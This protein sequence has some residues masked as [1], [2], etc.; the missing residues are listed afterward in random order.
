MEKCKHAFV[1]DN[2][3]VG[4]SYANFAGDTT[5]LMPC[6]LDQQHSIERAIEEACENFKPAELAVVDLS[7]TPGCTVVVK[8]VPISQRLDF[9]HTVVETIHKINFK[10]Q[11]FSETQEHAA[12]TFAFHIVT[13]EDDN[14]AVL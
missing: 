10:I 14:G 11:D 9:P 8:G 5:R 4:K 6:T 2:C 1:H 12:L 3:P 13:A 7:F